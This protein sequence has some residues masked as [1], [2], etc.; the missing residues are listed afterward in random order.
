VITIAF[1]AGFAERALEIVGDPRRVEAEAVDRRIVQR[2]DGDI[3]ADFI[4]GAHAW[5]S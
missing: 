2:D 3:F 1:T 5:S 4:G